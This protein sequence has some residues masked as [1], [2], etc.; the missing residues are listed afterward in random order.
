MLAHETYTKINTLYNRDEKGKIQLGEFSRPEFF[1]LYNTPWRWYLK[2]D[3][4]NTSIHWD[5]ELRIDGKTEQAHW[6]SRTMDFLKA[7]I[8]KEKMEAIFPATNGEYP[9]VIIYGETYGHG[10]NKVGGKYFKEK[11]KWGFRIFDV[12][13]GNFWLYPAGVEDVAKKLGVETPTDFGIM[14]IAEAEKKVIE[15]FKDP[16]AE[17]ELAAEGLVG[18]PV[19]QLFN[20]MG[21]R[22]MVKIKTRDYR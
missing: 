13:V 15:G 19:V 17:Q 16:I 1:M 9:K 3:G 11:C 4:T 22:V 7:L 18:R 2:I 6:D 12:K 10:I 5:G 14:T 8:T 21:E 20:R